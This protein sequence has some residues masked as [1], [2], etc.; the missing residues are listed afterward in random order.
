MWLCM[1]ADVTYLDSMSIF[2]CPVVVSKELLAFQKWQKMVI[3]QRDKKKK[4]FSHCFFHPHTI[5]IMFQFQWRKKSCLYDGNIIK[6]NFQFLLLQTVC[7]H[8]RR[9]RGRPNTDCI[10]RFGSLLGFV[11]YPRGIHNCSWM[12]LFRAHGISCNFP[13]HFICSNSSHLSIYLYRYNNRFAR[14]TLSITLSSRFKSSIVS[15]STT[16]YTYNTYIT[17]FSD[18]FCY[19]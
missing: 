12:L 11:P 14:V 2:I 16:S 4:Q 7:W 6:L 5:L 17:D 19:S 8:S 10:I 18:H 3:K 1:A 13:S 9:H 15:N